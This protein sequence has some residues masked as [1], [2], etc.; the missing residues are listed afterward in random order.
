MIGPRQTEVAGDALAS[1]QIDGGSLGREAGEAC[2]H[3]D[4]ARRYV[5]EAIFAEIVGECLDIRTLDDHPGVVEIVTVGGVEHATLDNSGLLGMSRLSMGGDQQREPAAENGKGVLWFH[6]CGKRL[7]RS[8]SGRVWSLI[9]SS[10]RCGPLGAS[11][12][13]EVRVP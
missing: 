11:R 6:G 7:L 12:P 3:R 13:T 5:G 2:A 10:D 1:G 8:G 9:R 4:G